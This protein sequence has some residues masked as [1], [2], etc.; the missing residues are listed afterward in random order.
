MMGG[1]WEEGEIRADV[2]EL[3]LQGKKLIYLSKGSHDKKTVPE[4]NVY[5]PAGRNLF[6]QNLFLQMQFET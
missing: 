6:G 4:V 1:G 3:F 5:K 2:G